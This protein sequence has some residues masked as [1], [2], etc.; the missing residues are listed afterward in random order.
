M[1]LRSYLHEVNNLPSHEVV[2]LRDVVKV[3]H[4]IANA[5][6]SANL[7]Q[8]IG[9]APISLECISAYCCTNIIK[10]STL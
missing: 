9:R 5:N 6:T 7:V 3:N 8:I 1:K 10:L 2:R 4:G